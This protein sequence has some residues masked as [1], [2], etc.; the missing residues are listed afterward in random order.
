MSEPQ[1]SPQDATLH[2]P[3]LRTERLVLRAPGMQ[4]WPAWRDFLASERTV[5]VGGKQT[6]DRAFADLASMIGHWN[7]RGYGRWIV[8]D[9]TSDQALGSV[10]LYYPVGWPEPEIAW[11]VFEHA[12][13][14]GYAHEAAKATRHYAYHTL[15]LTTLVSC[16]EPDNQ[17]SIALAERMGARFESTFQHA[18]I[19]ELLVYRHQGPAN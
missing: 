17:R 2:I 1:I 7:L 15:G 6:E 19:G 18:T 3:T 14:K 16:I 11:T 8:A 9:P 12:E 10:G 13:G 5:F 4:D